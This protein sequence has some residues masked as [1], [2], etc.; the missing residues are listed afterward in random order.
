MVF[1]HS[2]KYLQEIERECP[3]TL[4]EVKARLESMNEAFNDIPTITETEEKEVDNLE[5]NIACHEKT[6]KSLI[7]EIE[8]IQ[9]ELE[10][11]Q[12]KLLDG[13]DNILDKLNNRFRQLM[14][15]MGF[16]GEIALDKGTHELDFKNYGIKI[17]VKWRDTE[18]LKLLTSR[19]V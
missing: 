3:K 11:N 15:Y 14:E 4:A 13:I 7:D 17:L 8:E 19:S 12:S 2:N 6:V 1:F 5:Q 9:N 16:A 10:D 18:D